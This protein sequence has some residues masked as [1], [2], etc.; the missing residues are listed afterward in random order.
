MARDLITES[1]N[2]LNRQTDN[3]GIKTLDHIIIKEERDQIALGFLNV[4]LTKVSILDEDD[5]K[6]AY[7][8][9]DTFLKEKYKQ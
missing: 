1:V 5:V 9:A 8:N 6:E 7:R 2:S 3:K 4:R